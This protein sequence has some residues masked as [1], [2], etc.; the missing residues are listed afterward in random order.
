MS[1][2]QTKRPS[3]STYIARRAIALVIL[4][5]VIVVG[6]FVVRAGISWWRAVDDSTTRAKKEAQAAKQVEKIT[7]CD[8]KKLHFKV[9]L[10]EANP[11]AVGK[12]AVFKLVVSSNAN[13]SCLLAGAKDK[14]GIKIVTGADEVWNSTKCL[15]E[16]DPRQLLLGKDLTFTEEITWNGTRVND[17]VAG[18]VAS[19]GTYK[20]IPVYNGS[21]IGDKQVYLLQ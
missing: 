9:E 4:V 8:I 7:D 19:E 11:G 14:I 17:C 3:K 16:V 10:P 15:G 5:L 21:E 1:K 20:I 6:V 18:E 12:G 13:Q 2:K